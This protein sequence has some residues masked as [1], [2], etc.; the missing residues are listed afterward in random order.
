[1]GLRI[2]NQEYEVLKKK[3]KEHEVLQQR[4]NW[5]SEISKDVRMESPNPCLML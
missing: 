5:E 1:M 4:S 2:W 3:K